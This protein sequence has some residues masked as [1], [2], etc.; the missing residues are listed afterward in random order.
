MIVAMSCE[1][2]APARAAR[3]TAGTVDPCAVRAA[4]S[5]SSITHTGIGPS[6]AARTRSADAGESVM[7]TRA[8]LSDT[9]QAIWSAEDDW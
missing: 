7:T 6:T 5:P 9:I 1:V 2:T 8:P 3:S 4:S